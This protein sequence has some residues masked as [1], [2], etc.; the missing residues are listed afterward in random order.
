MKR[1]WLVV[2]AVVVLAG[3]VGW[4]ATRAPADPPSPDDRM[5]GDQQRELAQEIGYLK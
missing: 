1:L 3:G 5:N 2:V 4:W